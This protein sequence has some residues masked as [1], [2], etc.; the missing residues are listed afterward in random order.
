MVDSGSWTR[1]LLYSLSEGDLLRLYALVVR[2]GGVCRIT[3]SRSF[4][5]S[6]IVRRLA[7]GGLGRA[8]IFRALEKL[9]VRPEEHHRM[10]LRVSKEPDKATLPHSHLN[11]VRFF[12][13]PVEVYR[14]CSEHSVSYLA[15]K[16]QIE[17]L[18]IE[19]LA[20]AG[21]N[22]RK[23]WKAT[24]FNRRRIQR[25]IRKTKERNAD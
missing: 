8:G 5:V 16:R 6:D 25:I 4:A 13:D 7:K 9:G 21:W 19:K 11:A 10:I 24:G 2:N 14:R 20:E 22:S 17:Y 15:K 18:I 3:L 23:I 12:G 1:E